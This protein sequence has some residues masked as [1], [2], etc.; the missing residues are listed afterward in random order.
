MI[1]VFTFINVRTFGDEVYQQQLY[2]DVHPSG[3]DKEKTPFEAYSRV[4]Q[5]VLMP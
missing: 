3:S 5:M 4:R 1:K 2:C